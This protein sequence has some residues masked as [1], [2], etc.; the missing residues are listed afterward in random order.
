M[1]ERTISKTVYEC[2]HCGTQYGTAEDAWHCE[3]AYENMQQ[4]EGFKPWMIYMLHGQVS[5]DFPVTV[6]LVNVTH[7]RWG[8]SAADTTQ[9][10]CRK[11]VE[12]HSAQSND[13]Y[14]L[15]NWD[16]LWCKTFEDAYREHGILP[17]FHTSKVPDDVMERAKDIHELECA[18]IMR[19]RGCDREMALLWIEKHKIMGFAHMIIE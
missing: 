14:E 1:I 16:F 12:L 10:C 7:N 17:N 2:E 11:R 9:P 18:R 5:G 19:E 13:I 4:F 15:P 8:A 6:K 3:R